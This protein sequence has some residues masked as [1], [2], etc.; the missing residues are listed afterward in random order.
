MTTVSYRNYS[1]TAAALYDEF[2]VPTIARPVSQELLRVADLRAGEHV[3]DVACGTGVIAAEAARQVGASGS[4]TAVDIAPDMIEVARSADRPPG[5]PIDWQVADAASLPVPDGSQNVALCQMSVMFMEN[6]AAVLAEMHRVLVPGGRVV[7]N[8][9]GRIQPPF[10]DMEKSIV[11]NIGA[12][13]GA[14]VTT[15]FS[16]HDPEEL[17]ALLKGAGFSS[18]HTGLY[19]V[20]L[21]LPGPTE[22][23]WNYVNLTP[24]GSLVA[25]APEHAKTAMEN[26]MIQ[27]WA[28]SVVEG[29]RELVQ[30]IA[31]ASGRR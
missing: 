5:A 13:L 9:P 24:M 6:V 29:R 23:L 27:S 14:F 8:T 4:V 17:G 3:V 12:D 2:F 11:E 26:Q 1:G 30:P 10:E 22:F 25:G 19:E 16:M 15:V 7:I 31:L 20:N 18:V 21:D 28:P